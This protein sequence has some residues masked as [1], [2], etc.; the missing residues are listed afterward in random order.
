MGV[1]VLRGLLRRAH[2]PC[3]HLLARLGM[4]LLVLWNLTL[5]VLVLSPLCAGWPR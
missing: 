2:F 3:A 1:T 5:A 4:P